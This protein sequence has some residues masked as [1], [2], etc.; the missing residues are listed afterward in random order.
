MIETEEAPSSRAS[1]AI[2]RPMPLE[3]PVT[4]TWRFLMGT[5]LGRGRQRSRRRKKRARRGRKQ[6]RRRVSKE[7]AAMPRFC[8]APDLLLTERAMA[9]AMA[10][11]KFDAKKTK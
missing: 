8:R 5:T 7:E 11:T 4:R 3:P 6:R 10:M 1:L 2:S 9:M